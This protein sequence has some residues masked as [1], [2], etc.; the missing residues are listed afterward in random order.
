MLVKSQIELLNIE[1]FNREILW[2]DS[3]LIEAPNALSKHEF[4]VNG[5]GR[6]FRIN[7]KTLEK[8][9]ISTGF[10]K[11]CNNDHG[12]SPDGKTLIIS[13]HDP[14]PTNL[15]DWKTSKIYTLPIHGGIPQLITAK[16]CSFYHGVSPDGK[17]I[18]YTANRNNSWDIYSIPIQGGIE[19]KLSFGK[20]HADGSDYSHD[21]NYIY[22]NSYESASMEIWRMNSNGTNQVQITNDKHS[23][24]FPHPSPC[25][26]YVVYLCYVNN[27]KEDHPFGKEVLLRLYDLKDLSIKNITKTF[28]GGQGT[29][30]V[31]SWTADGKN[32]AFISYIQR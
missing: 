30:N 7:T 1:T 10:A 26:R 22:Y 15:E 14:D 31:N 18:T 3:C 32:L 29:I 23:N 4:I 20:G 9:L 5:S 19:K 17:T 16:D 2:S 21:G 6:M 8:K 11:N 25:G 28:Y 12:V 24:W 27:Q 13:S